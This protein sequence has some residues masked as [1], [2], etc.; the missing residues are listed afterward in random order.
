MTPRMLPEFRELSRKERR[1]VWGMAHRRAFLHWQ[2]W[3]GFLLMVFFYCIGSLIDHFWVTSIVIFFGVFLY[4]QIEVRV[5]LP[6]LKYDLKR[7][8]QRKSE[9]R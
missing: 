6:Y 2:T 8:S 7:R 4:S 3:I 9:V 5:A 1:R